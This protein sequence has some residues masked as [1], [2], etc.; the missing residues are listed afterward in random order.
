MKRMLL[1]VRDAGVP[2]TQRDSKEF[3]LGVVWVKHSVVWRL[4]CLSSG[5]RIL[6]IRRD[7]GGTTGEVRISMCKRNEYGIVQ[8]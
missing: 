8:A 2:N 6:G 1:I 7:D 4:L 5:D 3:I